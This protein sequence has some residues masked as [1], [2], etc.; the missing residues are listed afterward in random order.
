MYW[1]IRRHR[2]IHER[3]TPFSGI[4]LNS[5]YR[6]ESMDEVEQVVTHSGTASRQTR[7]RMYQRSPFSSAITKME[8]PGVAASWR[9]V[10]PGGGRLSNTYTPVTGRQILENPRAYDTVPSQKK[11]SKKQTQNK[12]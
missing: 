8:K 6:L 2:R 7:S 9:T 10:T 12:K 5:L 3:L 1:W 4:V 11:R